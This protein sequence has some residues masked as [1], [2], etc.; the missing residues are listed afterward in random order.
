[1]WDVS[2]A[3]TFPTVGQ[4]RC[5]AYEQ[6]YVLLTAHRPYV[7]QQ[8]LLFVR[9]CVRMSGN[10][11]HAIF[12]NA[13]VLFVNVRYKLFC[14]LNHWPLGLWLQVARVGDLQAPL[15]PA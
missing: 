10:D 7:L 2:V 12:L 13:A 4:F 14:G 8:R 11:P 5:S 1:M 9:V 3:V 6:D 15:I